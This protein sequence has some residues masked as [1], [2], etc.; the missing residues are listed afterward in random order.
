MVFLSRIS[1]EVFLAYSFFRCRI[2]FPVG[3]TDEEEVSYFWTLRV[4]P[5]YKVCLIFFL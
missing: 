2:E 3:E 1:Y 5:S 4:F